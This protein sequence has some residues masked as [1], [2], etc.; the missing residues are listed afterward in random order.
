VYYEKNM[1]IEE[2]ILLIHGLRKITYY[3]VVFTGQRP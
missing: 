3:E 2:I 1:S